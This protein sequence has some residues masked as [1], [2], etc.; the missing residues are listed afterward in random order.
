MRN[1]AQRAEDLASGKYDDLLCK[2]KEE[3]ASELE[4]VL[5]KHVIY[6]ALANYELRKLRNKLKQEQKKKEIEKLKGNVKSDSAVRFEVKPQSI[7]GSN[8]QK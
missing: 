6:G 5:I 1:K 2:S 7:G 4:E 8:E 3:L